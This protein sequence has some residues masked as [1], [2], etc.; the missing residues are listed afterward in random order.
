[1]LESSDVIQRLVTHLPLRLTNIISASL[2]SLLPRRRPTFKNYWKCTMPTVSACT[3]H[4][5]DQQPNTA[6]SLITLLPFPHLIGILLGVLWSI[7]I[8]I[9][10]NTEFPS[11]FT[12]KEI[13]KLYA[14]FKQID[15]DNS[16]DL[17]PDEIFNVPEL[18]QN[19][20]VKRVIS[21]FDKNKDGKISFS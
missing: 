8:V 10:G 11:Q 3:T 17:D 18:N 16:G 19:P 4:D 6:P 1:M 2:I 7:N 13:Q 20:L 12:E 5:D 14:R 9:M 21:I 15:E